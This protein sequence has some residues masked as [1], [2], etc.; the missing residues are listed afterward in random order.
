MQVTPQ[1][2]SAGTSTWPPSPSASSYFPTPPL[3]ALAVAGAS[4]RIDYSCRMLD[5]ARFLEAAAAAA[6]FLASKFYAC[7]C[8]E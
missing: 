2:L 4:G 7:A 5:Y 8:G 6:G 1:S 3:V